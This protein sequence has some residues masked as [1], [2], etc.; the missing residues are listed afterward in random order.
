MRLLHARLLVYLDEVARCG[1]IR[2][3]ALRLNVAASSINRQILALEADAGVPLFERLP[4]RL[5]LTA[6]GEVL[7]A[8]IRRTI[9][10][11]DRTQAHIEDLRGSR[12]G[13]V[14][15]AIMGGIGSDL[16]ART[17][18]AFR[19]RRPRVKLVFHRFG[20]ADMLAALRD[21]RVDLGLAF[22]MVAQPDMRVLLELDC[23]IGAVMAPSHKLASHP[24]VKLGDLLS[25]RLVW[26]AETMT[27]RQV[28]DR[29]FDSAGMSAE[30]FVEANEV[31]LMK[32]LV[33]LDKSVTLLNRLNVEAELQRGELVFVPIEGNNLP[34]QTL[35][36]VELAQRTP[37]ILSSTFAETLLRVADE[38]VP[39]L[40]A[41]GRS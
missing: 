16:L 23:A 2:K 38:I 17:A 12:R 15:V 31:E 13:E 40:T 10:D 7:I 36:L 35:R 19:E 5:R 34:V 21:G 25:C 30:P 3:A 24:R 11:F 41:T 32:R 9:H 14:T 4:H 1:S 8:H 20:L 22:G 18:M 27:M 26:P 6:A 39:G 33:V 28:L 29:I 37:T